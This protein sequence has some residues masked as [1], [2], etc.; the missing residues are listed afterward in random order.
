MGIDS[1]TPPG[2][3]GIAPRWTSSAKSAV[4]TALGRDSR[5]WFTMSH[6]ILNEIYAN[7]LDTA[8]IRDFGFIVTAQGYFSEDKRDADHSGGMVED[9][10]PAIRV[11]STARDGRYRITKTVLCDPEREVVLQEI[12]FEA[13]VGAQSDYSVHAIIAPRLV[14]AGAEKTA[15]YDDYK[16]RP[17]LF[18][19]GRGTVLAVA[20]SVPWLARSAGYVGISDGWQTLSRGEG[21]RPEYQRAEKGNVAIS[22]TIDFATGNE[23]AVLAVG[24]GA[25]P[26]ERPSA[27]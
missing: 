16:G 21:L 15:W 9:G 26:E 19:E 8:C 14:N 17:M 7:R 11:I 20:S 4:G 22:G 25:Q 1:I 18:A 23:L 6:G 2:A 12:A 3:P 24:F 27:L 5:V 13:L 10:V